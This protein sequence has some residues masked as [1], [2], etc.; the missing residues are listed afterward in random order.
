ME[1]IAQSFSAFRP[2]PQVVRKVSAV[3]TIF[4]DVDRVIGV[5]GLPTDRVIV[6]HGP[7]NKGKTSL[8]LGLGLSFLRS[9]H[10]FG[11]VDAEQSTPVEWL[12]DLY[13]EAFQH[14][15]FA[16]L[17]IGSYEK[18]RDGVRDFFQ[19]VAKGRRDGDIP[20]DTRALCLVDSLKK[21]VPER[22]WE[23][24][25][26]AV[27]ADLDDAPKKARFGGKAKSKGGVDAM[28]GRLGQIKAQYNSAWM[29]EL[30]PLLAQTNGSIILIGR[31]TIVEGTGMFA[32]D[33]ILL[34]GGKDINF[35]A[36]L[37]LRCD[38]Q[39]MYDGSFEAK[40][41]RYIGEKHTV[42]VM[43]TKIHGKQEA[44]PQGV[45]H[46]SNGVACPA[47]FDHARDLLCCAL[48][49]GVV[50]LAGSYYNCDGVAGTRNLGQGIDNALA[51][52]RAN[53]SVSRAVE[54]ECRTRMVA[55]VAA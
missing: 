24:L 20:E 9:D 4:P 16:A 25:Q 39:A 1:K 15:G 5:G 43:K 17:P 34:G 52:L 32:K 35:E 11:L 33:E 21:L 46:S 18:V 47:G 22:V 55:S 10:F 49:L 38:S 50:V 53:E 51:K 45:F 27:K 6:I 30:T 37:R 44:I 7:S 48:E 13:G 41:A 2:A 3:P 12:T 42:D 14:P 26:K 28:G 23:E 54:A 36:S 19:K 8:S 29:D 31:E 40:T